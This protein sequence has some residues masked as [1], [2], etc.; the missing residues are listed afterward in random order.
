MFSQTMTYLYIEQLKCARN[1]TVAGS[2]GDLKSTAKVKQAAYKVLGTAPFFGDAQL[3]HICEEIDKKFLFDPGANRQ[4]RAFVE[5]FKSELDRTIA[6]KK[7]GQ[8]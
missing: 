1:A 5:L 8:I 6:M 7:A 4:D 2:N 3:H